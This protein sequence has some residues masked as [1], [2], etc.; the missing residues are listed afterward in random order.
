M[1]TLE[2]AV[3]SEIK[4]EHADIFNLY[5]LKNNINLSGKEND[6]IFRIC[7]GKSV[8]EFIKEKLEDMDLF[9]KENQ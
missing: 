8:D 5:N 2:N 9:F 6:G 7:I 3:L 1:V 4:K